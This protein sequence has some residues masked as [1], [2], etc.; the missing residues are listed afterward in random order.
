[1][2]RFPSVRNRNKVGRFFIF[3]AAACW[4]FW[5]ATYAEDPEPPGN[6]K[7]VVALSDTHQYIDDWVRK[8]ATEGID[9]HR[10][11]E[12]VFGQTLHVA[13]LV[14]GYTLDDKSNMEV[15]VDHQVIAPN[16]TIL[17]DEPNYS[18]EKGPMPPSPSFVMTDPAMD[19]VFD[20]ED[21]EGTY[22][23]EATVHDKV[24]R[25]E[26]HASTEFNV[27]RWDA[28]LVRNQSRYYSEVEA[29]RLLNEGNYD[30]AALHALSLYPVDKSVALRI[31]RRLKG[32]VKE[33]IQDFLFRVYRETMFDDLSIRAPSDG[34]FLVV[35]EWMHQKAAWCDLLI[36][37]VMDEEEVKG[38]G[39]V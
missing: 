37:K 18:K 32:K 7:L 28:E 4:C 23:I 30:K 31:A 22:R 2:D 1:M 34:R 21:P 29:N 16:G 38:G 9:I 14:T 6:L 19:L 11:E 24:A 17:F 35:R 26:A 15:T 39:S 25:R 3:L 20:E 5:T 27:L 33:P 12:F 13:F 36:R 10:V 8:P